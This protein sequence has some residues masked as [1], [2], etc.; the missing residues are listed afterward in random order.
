MQ[1]KVWRCPEASQ[2]ECVMVYHCKASGQNLDC[3]KI[4]SE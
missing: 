2:G 4:D 1:P 3:T